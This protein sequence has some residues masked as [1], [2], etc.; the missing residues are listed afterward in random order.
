[1]SKCLSVPKELEELMWECRA[2]IE[3]RDECIA[4]LFKAKKAIT[5]GVKAEKV[6][7]DRRPQAD[8]SSSAGSRPRPE[9]GPGT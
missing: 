6:R 3:C 5:Y 8:R 1:M 2:C 9:L 4:S 7:R